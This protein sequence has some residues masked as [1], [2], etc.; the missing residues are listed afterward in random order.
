MWSSQ[1]YECYECA[2]SKAQQAHL[3]EGVCFGAA[4]V[5]GT[6]VVQV[7]SDRAAVWTQLQAALRYGESQQPPRPAQQTKISMPCGLVRPF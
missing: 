4:L 3:A 1:E 2:T 6:L 7:R 5:G